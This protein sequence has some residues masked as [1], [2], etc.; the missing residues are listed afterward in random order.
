MTILV[1]LTGIFWYTRTELA[2]PTSAP[3][4]S[5]LTAALTNAAGLPL[6][7]GSRT[8]TGAC[9]AQGPLPDPDCTPG[10]VFADATPSEICV[11]G[12]TKTVRSVSTSMRKKVYQEYGVSY[13][14]A[15]G[16]YEVDH[17]IPLEL[18]GSNDIANLFLEAAKPAP[19][20]PEK[21]LVENYL[22]H[23]VCAGRVSLIGAQGQI[24]QDWLAVYQGLTPDQI[25]ALRQEYANWSGN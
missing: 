2:G 12:Y 7:L 10:A 4:D 19:G 25:A 9:Q 21:D 22:N 23:E 18:G 16:M 11:A 8:K 15:R 1:L 24:A 5:Q 20:F 13:P 6:Q 14:Q 17:L 3:R